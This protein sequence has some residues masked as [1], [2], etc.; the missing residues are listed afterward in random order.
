MLWLST[1][2]ADAQPRASRTRPE[3]PTLSRGS[4]PP[5]R[6]HLRLAWARHT[7]I[8][9]VNADPAVRSTLELVESYALGG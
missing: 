6:A 4:Q 9:V 1:R 7:E 3:S 5:A 8:F 2:T